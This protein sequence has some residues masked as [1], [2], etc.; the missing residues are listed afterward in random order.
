MFLTANNVAV[1]LIHTGVVSSA[2]VVN[3][4]FLLVEAGRRNRNF[5]VYQ[6][7]R[8][9]L[10]IKQVKSTEPQAIATL[11]R[12]AEF[13]RRLEDGRMD[14]AT[15]PLIPR[16]VRYDP[17]RY[18]LIVELVPEAQSVAEYHSRDIQRL[19]TTSRQFGTALASL[20]T[21]LALLFNPAERSLFPLQLPWALTLDLTGHHAIQQ[22]G[23]VGVQ[24][25]SALQRTP[26]LQAH[27]G[28]LRP[29]WQ[30]E[31]VIHGDMKW[32][33]ALLN[34]DAD[35]LTQL[36]VV[37]W[38]LV[39]FGDS[40]WDVASL[41]K[42]HIVYA[43]F[44]LFNSGAVRA[45][46]PA[47]NMEAALAACAAS[48]REFFQ[49]YVSARRIPPAMLPMYAGRSIR[50]TAA[51]LVTAVLEYLYFSPTMT[52]MMDLILQTASSLLQQPQQAA[53]NVLGIPAV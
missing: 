32:E 13:Y 1:Y 19:H 36:H 20:H 53:W 9:G 28:S 40:A 31:T 14:A 2:A 4:G 17:S 6:G 5:K 25:S 42:E 11:Q 46:Q 35:S 50:F 3:D 22:L 26:G 48:A 7:G 10:F 30:W 16:L 8:R 37:D 44:A 15:R 41:L 52:Q 21:Q 49:E 39:D 18:V 24:L 27:L 33:N 29:L 23:A 12:E 43:L 45:G 34:Q 38:E 47:V 51:R